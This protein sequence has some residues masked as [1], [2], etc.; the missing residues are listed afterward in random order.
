MGANS[1]E[2]DFFI[3]HAS[4]DKDAFVRPLWQQLTYRGARVWFDEFSL[5]IGDSLRESIDRGLL[6]SRF[7]VVILSPSFF[8]KAWPRRELDGLLALGRDGRKVVLPVW[9]GVTKADVEA[10]SP[11]LAGIV[12]GRATDGLEALVDGLCRLIEGGEEALPPPRIAAPDG[13]PAPAVAAAGWPD[14]PSATRF[15]STEGARQREAIYT[16]TTAADTFIQ[17]P[18]AIPNQTNGRQVRDW[19]PVYGPV[20]DRFRDVIDPFLDAAS[21]L[22]GDHLRRLMRGLRNVFEVRRDAGSSWIAEAPRLVCRVIAD[23]LLVHAYCTHDW[24]R[25]RAVGDPMFTSYVGRIP[26]VLAP[27]YRHLETL[28][29]DARTSAEF[30]L[31]M[32]LSASARFTELKIVER[33]V[34]G[35]Y[36]AICVGTALAAWARE[37]FQAHRAQYGWGIET[38]EF[39]SEMTNWEEEPGILDTFARW[40]GSDPPENFR[41][42]LGAHLEDLIAIE[43]KSG[44]FLVIPEAAWATVGRI[45]SS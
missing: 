23:Q 16:L 11:V 25:L 30:S 39:W 41:A 6:T 40:A 43:Q 7:G 36:A 9:Y 42:T 3:S 22:D 1:F 13:D 31:Q 20:L 14:T 17:E 33:H 5:S 32:L 44:R 12:A 8:E 27:E 2:H 21:T 37:G 29:H 34:K 19:E 10:F 28:G 35:A 24:D 18:P 4:E 15:A 26:W 38:P 45:S